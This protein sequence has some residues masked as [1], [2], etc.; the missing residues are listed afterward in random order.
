MINDAFNLTVD[1]LF[2]P[3]E[4]PELL[5]HVNDFIKKIQ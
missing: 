2:P 1:Q 5:N 3:K 4:S